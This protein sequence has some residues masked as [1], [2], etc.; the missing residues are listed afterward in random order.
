MKL[1]QN[2][3]LNLEFQLLLA[4]SDDENYK[5]E[6]EKLVKINNLDDYVIFENHY[7]N[8]DNFF[9]KIDLFLFLTE[10]E[11]F[12]LIVLEAIENNVPVVCSNI[13][14]LSEFVDDSYKT[15]V[16]REN[17]KEI[18]DFVNKIMKN[19]NL[20]KKIQLKQKSKIQK[21]S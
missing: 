14:P 4:G 21:N 6:L 18:A 2:C 10:S 12:G 3:D 13:E 5:Q 9:E 7:E 1:P 16:N 15:L 11:G 8:I 19:S 17:T 20:L